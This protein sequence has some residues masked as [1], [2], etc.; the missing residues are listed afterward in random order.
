MNHVSLQK[1]F[2]ALINRQLSKSGRLFESFSVLFSLYLNISC[3][4]NDY[5]N[6]FIIIEWIKSSHSSLQT[7]PSTM[8]KLVSPTEKQK[9]WPG[10]PIKNQEESFMDSWP[11]LSWHFL[12]GTGT[13]EFS[14]ISESNATKSIPNSQF[15]E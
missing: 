6:N 2:F 13:T 3:F 15:L 5:S 14:P 12:G 8:S 11:E 10:S 9:P 7:Q 1:Q 4:V